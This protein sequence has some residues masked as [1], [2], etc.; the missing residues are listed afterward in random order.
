MNWSSL[1]AI[2]GTELL[3]YIFG[4]PK[5]NETL[6]QLVAKYPEVAST[7]AVLAR[8]IP[9]EDKTG[10][11]RYMSLSGLARW[12]EEQNIS[13]VNLMRTSTGQTLPA[14]PSAS[15]DKVLDAL[16]EVAHD[17]WATYLAPPPDMVPP[18]FWSSISV[19]LF[20]N[21]H[22]DNY[23]KEFMD[24]PDLKKL[25]PGASALNNPVTMDQISQIQSH[26]MTTAG[27][28]GTQQLI[29]VMGFMINDAYARVLLDHNHLTWE[30][31]LKQLPI[32]LKTM[33][34]LA[35]GKVVDVPR[36]IGYSGVQV[37][38]QTGHTIGHLTLRAPDKEFDKFFL[39]DID[40]LTTVCETTYPLQLIDIEPWVPSSNPQKY[41]EKSISKIESARKSEQKRIDLIRLAVLFASPDEQFLSLSERDSFTL[42][43][44]SAGGASYTRFIL[45]HVPIVE[46]DDKETKEAVTWASIISKEHPDSLDIGIRRL[47]QS[48]SERVEATDGFVDAV[49]AWENVFGTSQETVFRVTASLAKL[50]EPADLHTR[51][52]LLKELKKLYDD[53]SKL[54]HGSK[55]PTDNKAFEMRN[56]AIQIAILTFKKLYIERKDLIPLKSDQ[57]S[58][59]LL[60]E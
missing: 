44:S 27:G 15:N 54:V 59:K 4:K 30:Q 19:G 20:G 37:K 36:L 2:Y 13:L 49:I 9:I 50:L 60:L 40:Q 18:F 56:R 17:F 23:A 12:I 35:S 33:R 34:D 16:I 42:V 5:T 6:D 45:S 26:W 14:I 10:M 8:G 7:L 43:P 31:L 11:G 38:S 3:E 1:E 22:A 39:R 51:E 28:G 58:A 25:F 55:E 53:R 32:S 41:F 47:L 21:P 52:V 48:V 46:L 24:D 29:G 57:R